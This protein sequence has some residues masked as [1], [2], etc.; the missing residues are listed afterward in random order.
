[1][2]GRKKRKFFPAEAMTWEEMDR[3]DAQ[4]YSD[5]KRNVTVDEPGGGVYRGGPRPPGDPPIP[6]LFRRRCRYCAKE[7]PSG[8]TCI[9]C[10][11]RGADTEAITVDVG[12]GEYSSWTLPDGR[13][14]NFTPVVM[15]GAGQLVITVPR[16][17]QADTLSVQEAQQML[18][19]AKRQFE[20]DSSPS[21]RDGRKIADKYRAESARQVD[22]EPPNPIRR[23]GNADA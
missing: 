23:K 13:T 20:W 12:P 8:D 19:D 9:A 15:A 11:L 2:I 16:Q 18:D 6:A 5:G 21:A 10:T 1:M 3:R 22:L 14:V 7:I 4:R 17:P